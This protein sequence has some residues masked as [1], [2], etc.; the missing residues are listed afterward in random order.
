MLFPLEIKM[1]VTG[2]NTFLSSPRLLSSPLQAVKGSS[3]KMIRALRRLMDLSVSQSAS[4]HVH[5][6]ALVFIM[7]VNTI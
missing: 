5:M 1:T 4:I 3:I 2:V 6:L 7:Q